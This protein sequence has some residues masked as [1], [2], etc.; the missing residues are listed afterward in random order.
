MTVK[1]EVVC[2]VCKSD[3]VLALAWINKNA[4]TFVRWAEGNK[5]H[6]CIKCNKI[7]EVSAVKSINPTTLAWRI[8]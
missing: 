6:F 8:L 2:S 1:E 3:K 4:K 5:N 7:V